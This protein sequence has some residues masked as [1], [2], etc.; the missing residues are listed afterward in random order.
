MSTLNLKYLKSISRYIL[1]L[2]MGLF[3]L[4]LAGCYNDYGLSTSEYDVVATYYK[5]DL[6]YSSFKTY[7]MPDTIIHIV[8]EGEEDELGR[9]NDQLILSLVEEN[10][11]N[12]GYR[13]ITVSGAD[14]GIILAATSST[15]LQVYYNYSWG[16]YWG[17]PGYGYYY[18]PY[19]GGPTV[20]GYRTGTVFINMA[21]PNEYDENQKLLATVWLGVING[22]LE[23]T[24]SNIRDR[25]T[26]DINQAYTQSPYLGTSN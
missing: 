26:R 2:V 13:R 15:N 24:K 1:L 8:E 23:D 10:M 4:T 18:P 9:S 5:E 22:L 21:D 19:W 17:Y 3:V 16:G 25:L 14:L 20:E 6:N 12:L 11:T 7:F